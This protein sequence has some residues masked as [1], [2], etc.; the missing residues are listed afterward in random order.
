MGRAF[1]DGE[2][3]HLAYWLETTGTRPPYPETIR[4]LLDGKEE[5]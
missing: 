1:A 5:F 4:V 3:L 2:L